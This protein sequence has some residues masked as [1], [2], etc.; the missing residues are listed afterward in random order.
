VAAK[1]IEDALYDYVSDCLAWDESPED[2][3]VLL[4][5][6]ESKRTRNFED[7]L[8][9]TITFIKRHGDKLASVSDD[10]IKAVFEKRAKAAREFKTKYLGGMPKAAAKKAP[11]AKVATEKREGKP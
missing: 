9:T 1:T 11:A 8:K 3:I 7:I 4:R 10:G 6:M 2:Y 5:L